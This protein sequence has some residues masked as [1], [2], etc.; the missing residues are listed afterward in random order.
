MSWLPGDVQAYET[1]LDRY[2]VTLS[3]LSKRGSRSNY[4]DIITNVPLVLDPAEVL[5]TISKDDIKLKHNAEAMLEI[6]EK[7]QVMGVTRSEMLALI[8]NIIATRNEV[9]S[10]IQFL[11]QTKLIIPVGI[12][13]ISW[14]CHKY[15]RDWLIH[16]YR[17]NRV[18]TGE[19]LESAKFSGKLYQGH[20]PSREEE[21]AEPVEDESKTRR[22]RLVRRRSL[23]SSTGGEDIKISHREKNPQ[24]AA[25]VS[26]EVSDAAKKINWDDMEEILVQIRPWVRIEG[27]L[28]RRVLD[29][30]LGAVLGAAM[31]YPGSRLYDLAARFSPALQPV[32]AKELIYMLTQI[33]AV[34]LIKMSKPKK[35]GLWSVPE[36]VKLEEPDILDSD[37][38]II[39]EA[40]VDAILLLGQFIGNKVYTTDFAC[41][42]PCHP[43][44][45]M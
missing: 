4:L 43:D 38:E 23:E 13:D 45:R 2:G 11:V 29:R 9:I 14:V 21:E 44:R 25:K 15:C 18:K 22:K 37:Q 10:T 19:K 35:P 36:P 26:H 16:T 30:L 7:G 27:S 20:G 12:L 3:G 17:V 33:K 39:I 31:Q 1:L 5:E 40:S 34:K 24:M 8:P 32:H 6:V 28:N 42:C 41:Q